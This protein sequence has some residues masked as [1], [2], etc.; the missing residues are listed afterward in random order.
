M[1]QGASTARRSAP[2]KGRPPAPA[3]SGRRRLYVAV[4]V[5]VLLGGALVLRA[6]QGRDDAPT[7]AEASSAAAALDAASGIGAD[8]PPPW[9]AP[10]EPLAQV[11]A[12]GLQLGEMGTAEHYHFHLDV[13]VN[14]E[15]V[16]VP[17]DLG[18]DP[19]TGAMSYLHTHTAD[20]VV[21][22]EAGRAGQKFTLGQLFTQWDV[23]LSANQLGGLRADGANTLSAYVD[24]TKAAGNPAHLRVAPHQEIALVYGPAD[25]VVDVPSD[26]AFAQGD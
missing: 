22:I 8:T 12:A 26:Y 20:G 2:T 17:A 23:R 3:P 5:V 7:A 21:H 25:Q 19:A 14:G 11:R 24:G 15:P 18:V 4:A 10:A 16:P 13:I 1:A 9:P 6:W